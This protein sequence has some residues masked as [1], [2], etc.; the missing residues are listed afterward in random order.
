MTRSPGNAQDEYYTYIYRDPRKISERLPLGEP[1]YVGKGKGNRYK[2]HIDGNTYHQHMLNKIAKMHREGFEPNIEIIPALNEDHALF[3]ET[4]CIAVIGRKDLGKGPLL[5]YTDGGEGLTNPGPQTR[6]KLRQ[7]TLGNKRRV[8]KHHTPLQRINIGNGQRGWKHSEESL[9]VM[10][11]KHS[12]VN[13][14]RALE[15][16][17]TH[18]DGWI[19]QVIALG[20]WIKTAP[21][22]LQK[23]MMYRAARLNVPHKGYKV[24]KLS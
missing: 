16:E 5:N 6:A 20:H 2:A 9:K 23:S 24:R 21:I 10:S 7:A 14:A 22:K 13:N 12:G 1:F 18:P 11:E 19:E 3:M 15:W 8:G 17:V 4:T